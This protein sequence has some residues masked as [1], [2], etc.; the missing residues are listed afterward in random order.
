MST[1]SKVRLG[2]ISSAGGSVLKELGRLREIAELDLSVVTDRECGTEILCRDLG[3]SCQR[4]KEKDNE[5]FSRKSADFFQKS[6]GADGVLLFFTRIV[7][8]DL[9]SAFPTFNIHPSL[10]PAFR[11]FKPLEQA[12]GAGV[13]VVGA[14]LHLVDDN[15]DGGPIVAQV[16]NSISGYDSAYL[17]K[18]SFLQ[19][20]L[21]AYLLAD[22]LASES[23]LFNN[24]RMELRRKLVGG[25]AYNPVIKNPAILEIF[26]RIEAENGLKIL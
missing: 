1:K 14:T 19:K 3:I 12:A 22:L 9:F 16:A 8:G 18:L 21:L 4:I 23:V 25:R 26:G 13:K 2:I 5:L 20:T 6:G 24:G 7:G 15:V 11:G 17:E 10:L